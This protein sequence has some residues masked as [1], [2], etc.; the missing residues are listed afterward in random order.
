MTSEP[1]EPVSPEVAEKLLQ[2]QVSGM[3]SSMTQM[4]ALVSQSLATLD[5]RLAELSARVNQ[6]RA[7][8]PG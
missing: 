4:E 1:E 5:S 3:M 8:R 7:Q 2:D 6:I